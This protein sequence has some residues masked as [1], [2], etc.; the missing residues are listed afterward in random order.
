M[1]FPGEAKTDDA[2]FVAVP[3]PTFFETRSS[4]TPVA[5]AL[6]RAALHTLATSARATERVPPEAMLEADEL[7][8]VEAGARHI[9]CDVCRALS[10]AALGRAKK[11]TINLGF[12]PRFTSFRNLT[13]RDV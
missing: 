3:S 13:R 2:S 8:Q 9:R 11:G 6:P 10:K 1:Y 4:A 7:A 12:V 5:A